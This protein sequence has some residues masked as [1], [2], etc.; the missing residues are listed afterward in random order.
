MPGLH[1]LWPATWPVHPHFAFELLAYSIG[2]QVFLWGLR[3]AP[4]PVEDAL[5]RAQLLGAAVVG[6]VVGAKGLF[7]LEDPA[8]TA[9]HLGELQWLMSG[10]T[11]VGGLLGGTLSV[12]L[13]KRL[14]GVRTA[15]GDAFVAP[16]VVGLCVG[17]VGCFLT[18]VADGTHGIPTSL[19]WAMDLGDGVGRHPA[20]LYEIAFVA[21]LGVLHRA[22]RGRVPNGHRFQ[23]FLGGY[24]A[25]RLGVE[26]VKTQPFPYLG[27]SA[28][29]VA[30][31]VGLAYTVA[32]LVR[33][34]RAARA[35]PA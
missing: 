19:P 8:Q 17:R 3:R 6:A 10:R 29:Q 9:A 27:L 31:L 16:L 18:G 15:T 2:F 33:R 11:I 4:D 20:A 30:C 21:A 26:V 14:L 23:L 5:T 32:T 34:G 12:E 13:A 1:P 25:F 22:L 24:F 35:A 28:I 7:L